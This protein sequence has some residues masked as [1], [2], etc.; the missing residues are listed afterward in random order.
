MKIKTEMENTSHWPITYYKT[1]TYLHRPSNVFD[2][3][4][5]SNRSCTPTSFFICRSSLLQVVYLRLNCVIW[6]KRL[7]ALY[8]E[9]PSKSTTCLNKTRNFSLI[10]NEIAYVLF[11]SFRMLHEIHFSNLYIP[12]YHT[13]HRK[14]RLDVSTFVVRIAFF[15][16]STRTSQTER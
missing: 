5:D 2:I 10:N 11:R 15:T 6:R 16:N 3:F 8:F 12:L 4:R 7:V 13:Y 9:M 14:T 1:W